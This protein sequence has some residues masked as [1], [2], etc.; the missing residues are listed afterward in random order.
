MK[1]KKIKKKT[2]G[3]FTEFKKFAF[4]DS[5]L[6]IAIGIMLGTAIKSVIDS[7]VNDVLTPPIAKITSGIDFSNLY[8]ALGTEKYD[9]LQAAQDAG[10]V[11]ITYG[12]FINA[13]I[14]FLITAFVLFVIV[15][16]G[17]KLIKKEKK[18]E[19]KVTK[20]CPYC[21]SEIA[22]DAKKCAYCTSQVK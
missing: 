16:Q 21:K 6:G 18:E 14:S 9:S 19:A 7:L 8:F 13:I 4:K 3:F 11:V 17:T 12:N 20:I 22:I 5:T 1:E 15:N 2:E 10:A